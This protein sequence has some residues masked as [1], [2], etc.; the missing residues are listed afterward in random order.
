MTSQSSLSS[1]SF[2]I[3]PVSRRPV[4]NYIKNRQIAAVC[5]QVLPELNKEQ[6]FKVNMRSYLI[7]NFAVNCLR[8]LLST[9]D[10]LDRNVNVV[11]LAKGD[12]M[13]K[14]WRKSNAMFSIFV[15]VLK[16]KNIIRGSN[17]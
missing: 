11:H 14:L 13:L 6:L 4:L 10:L 1:N 8:A 9:D 12:F 5:R 2:E 16:Y 15:H 17:V 7:G 3:F